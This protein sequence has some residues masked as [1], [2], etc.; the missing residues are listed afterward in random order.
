MVQSLDALDPSGETLET[1]R[2]NKL[3]YYLCDDS[4]IEKLT[5]Y[6]TKGMA[7]LS[8][9]AVISSHFPHFHELAHLLV[10]LLQDQKPAQT[11]P[12]VQEGLACLLGG[13]WGR[14]PGTV[15]YTG[16]VHQSFG[17]GELKEAL[18]QDGFYSMN[19]GAD[20][21]Y[22]LGTV[23]CELVR[24]EAGWNGVLEL[25]N[26]VSGHLAFVSALSADDVALQITEICGW[27]TDDAAH[28]LNQRISNLWPE[29][30][31]S[32][33]FPAGTFLLGDADQEVSNSSDKAEIWHHESSQIVKVS[34]SSFPVFLLSEKLDYDQA[35]SS[36]FAEHLPNEAYL[37]QR[38]G[39]R[40]DA[41][42][43][44]LYDYSANQ[45]LATWVASFTDEMEKCGT[46]ESGL[47]FEVNDPQVGDFGFKGICWFSVVAP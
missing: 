36:L 18:T 17:M 33:I 45:L 25:N 22:P 42:N 1:L 21:A 11:L 12:L 19:G 43:I 40:C 14:A 8:G 32:G 46:N 31:R 29:F 5:G 7:D 44:A 9:R 20:V 4:T 24:R 16:W 41:E 6:P 38:Y 15:L 26:R 30:R 39:L 3:A 34:A 28:E 35:S 37:G 47:Y 10:Y 27:D 2:H 23:L 13:R